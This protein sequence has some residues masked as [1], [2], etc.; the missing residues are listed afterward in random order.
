MAIITIEVIVEVNPNE[1]TS[2]Q[3]TD[4]ESSVEE[5]LTEL[6]IEHD[7]ADAKIR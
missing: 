1:V 2:E 4:I 6:G 7:L 5:M 3:L